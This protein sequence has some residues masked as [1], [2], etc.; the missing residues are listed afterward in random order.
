MM[1]RK[2][3]LRFFGIYILV[4]VRNNGAQFKNEAVQKGGYFSCLA[5]LLETL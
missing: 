1:F 4:P 5:K 2:G 3:G